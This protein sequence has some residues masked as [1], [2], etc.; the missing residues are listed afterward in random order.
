MHTATLKDSN[1]EVV[2]KVLKPGVE[3]VLVAD[4]SFIYG[5]SLVLEWLNPELSR[6]SLSGI[7]SDIRN[8]ILDETDFRKEANNLKE[9]DTFLTSAGITEAVCPQVS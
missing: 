7:V 9:F 2:I 6:T 5:S 3:D 1:K 4:L 8:S